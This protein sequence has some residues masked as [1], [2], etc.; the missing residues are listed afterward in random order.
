[1]RKIKPKLNITLGSKNITW[2]MLPPKL[3][4][5]LGSKNITMG[6][7]TKW[8]NEDEQQN[9]NPLLCKKG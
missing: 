3:N 6:Y 1:M 8:L 7:V 4:I 5:T 2:V 9:I